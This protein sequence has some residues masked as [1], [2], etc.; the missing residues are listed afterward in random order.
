MEQDLRENV[1]RLND[2][3]LLEGAYPAGTLPPPEALRQYDTLVPG[4]AERIFRLAEDQAQYRYQLET[5]RV[6]SETTRAVLAMCFTAVISFFMVVGGITVTVSREG[7][8]GAGVA[9]SLFGV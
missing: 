1:A 7:D 8:P 4:A 2:P 5:A 6:K 9:I 3:T